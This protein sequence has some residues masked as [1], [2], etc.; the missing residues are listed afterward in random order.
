MR[1]RFYTC[2]VFT[3]Q[4]FGGNPLA[5]FPDATGIPEDSLQRIAREFNLSETVF[6]YP[7]E[8]P[9]H[10]KRLRIFTPAAE[11]PF[12]GHPTVGAAHAL[13]TLGKVPLRGAETK[14]VFEE[15]VGPVPV[16]IRATD[17][18]PTFAQLTAA[19]APEIGPP[20]PGRSVL[21]DVLALEA[22]DIQGGMTAPQGVSCGLPFLIVPLKDRD[23]V[24]RAHVRMDHWESSIKSYWA[25]QILVFSRDAEREDADVHARVFVPGLSVPED[26]ATGSAATALGAYLAARDTR[27]DGTL[28]WV[29]EQGIEMGRPSLLEIVVEKAGG[30]IQS[31]KVGG[32]T[33]MVS[34]GQIETGD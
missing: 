23:A 18:K 12:A 16:L 31:V 6:V 13:A 28:R 4:L 8:R 25:P 7:P 1:A 24:R 30:D 34:E 3:N 15:K 26:P 32:E 14:I 11:L 33:V 22:T 17:G 10:T 2:D 19:Q 27:A 5:V 20:T 29:V 9:E 21:A